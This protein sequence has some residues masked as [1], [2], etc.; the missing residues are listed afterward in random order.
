MVADTSLV[1]AAAGA[2]AWRPAAGVGVG[3]AWRPCA[4]MDTVKPATINMEPASH[5]DLMSTSRPLTRSRARL[6]QPQA[7]LA[8]TVPSRTCRFVRTYS[9]RSDRQWPR[10]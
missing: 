7:M 2:A 1:A 5:R 10:S 4:D 9:L 8:A 3:V 6:L